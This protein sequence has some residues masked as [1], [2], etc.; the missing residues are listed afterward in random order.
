MS[1][2]TFGRYEVAQ[3][4][5]AGAFG[6]VYRAWDAKLGRPVAL[7]LLHTDFNEDPSIRARFEREA[8]IMASLQHPHIIPIHDFGEQDGTLFI[9]MALFGGG[10]LQRQMAERAAEGRAFSSD[11]TFAI[12]EPIC[13]ALDR[14]HSLGVV[15]RDLKPGNI[16]FDESGKLAITDFG[17]ARIFGGANTRATLTASGQEI[18][19]PLYMAP[20][21]WK[22]AKEQIDGRTD[23]Y[24]LGCLAYQLLTGRAP[25]AGDSAYT[26][27]HAHMFDAAPKPSDSHR[28][29]PRPWDQ[30]VARLLAKNPGDRFDTA[31]AFLHWLREA[32][33]G[34]IAPLPEPRTNV[35]LVPNVPTSQLPAFATGDT[36]VPRRSKAPLFAAAAIIVFLGLGAGLYLRRSTAPGPGERSVN[37]PNPAEARPASN[38]TAPRP[39]AGPEPREAGGPRE[40]AGARDG[41]P[42]APF[43]GRD[44]ATATVAAPF[45]NSLGLRFVPVGNEGGRP[46]LVCR[47]ET[48]VS[49]FRAF[50]T[51]PTA[52]M[53]GR[54][55]RYRYEAPQMGEPPRILTAQGWVTADATWERPGFAQTDEHPVTCVSFHDAMAFAEWLGNREVEA[56]QLP[57]G[58]R[59][60]VPFAS[61][62]QQ[63]ASAA[64]GERTPNY[65]GSEAR[66]A[67]WPA[68]LPLL[69]GWQDAFPRTAPPAEAVLFSGL[70]GNVWEWVLPQDPGQERNNAEIR[71]GAWSTS[72]PEET[73]VTFGKTEPRSTRRSD[74]G[75]RL[76][77][78]QEPA[79]RPIPPPRGQAGPPAAGQGQSQGPFRPPAVAAPTYVPGAQ[80]V[81]FGREAPTPAPTEP[82]PPQAQPGEP[83]GPRP[84]FPRDRP[85][86]PGPPGA[87]GP[88]R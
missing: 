20:E 28:N 6:A 58:W 86:R 39:P 30:G 88:P 49:D 77:L 33:G 9:V 57:S 85:P 24:A 46:L 35:P 45:V 11:E 72:R 23:L 47:I 64:A 7:K 12:L 81:P 3:Q 14:A 37:P 25:F 36:L 78:V 67:N 63:A 40:A 68:S 38:Q 16:L 42:A 13:S 65:A 8:K 50:V 18:G 34:R 51:S 10:T 55:E 32:L 84:L 80:V 74:L 29:L 17:I 82:P 75:F 60:R 31:G 1:T 21:Q 43:K 4:L 44:P 52:R 73:N 26:L 79:G 76:V 83:N 56:G 5:G 19:T 27:M 41:R 48:R 22:G 70:R 15:H 69:S 2:R 87:G 54:D 53:I 59:Y 66:D 62:W 71:G 61:E